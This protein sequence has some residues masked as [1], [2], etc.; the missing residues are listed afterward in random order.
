MRTLLEAEP[1]APVSEILSQAAD[2]LRSSNTTI[3]LLAAPSLQGALA[4]APLEAALVDAGVPYRRRFRLEAPSEGS[5]VHILGPAD[6]SGPKLSSNPLQLSLAGTVVDGLTGH[7][8]D[9]RK[10]PLTAVAQSHAL[11]QAIC[12]D[13]ARIRRLRPWAISGN[14][15][16]SALDTTYDPVFTALRDA[17]VQDGSI[18]VVP[19]PEVPE[20]NIS[21]STWIDPAALDAVT[22]RW[23]S[24]D[25]EGRARALSHLMRPALSRS[26][27]STARLEE[28]GW[29]CVLGP[30]WSTDLAGQ[31]T[32]AA[33]LWKENSAAVAAGRVTDSLLRRGVIPQ[34]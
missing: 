33:G 34:L 28:I 32:T 18:K 16:H 8:G 20:P 17:L 15:L 12:P 10:G 27:P 13:G 23:P 21:A 6:E 14:W 29:H 5:W 24:L 3:L 11:A 22:S 9:S 25:M 26:T 4:I 31:I 1:L 19:L 7:Q 30:G 2:Q